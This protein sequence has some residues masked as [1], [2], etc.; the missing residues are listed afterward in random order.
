M[1]GPSSVTPL[2]VL[3]FLA[4]L[5]QAWEL[6]A[7]ALQVGSATASADESLVVEAGATNTLASR[8][9]ASSWV[10]WASDPKEQ[11]ALATK[12][13]YSMLLW[14][15]FVALAALFYNY[16]KQFPPKDV[17][18][19]HPKLLDHQWSFGLFA[20]FDTPAICCLTCC[21]MPIRWADTIR[22]AGLM[23]FW[24]ALVVFLGVMLTEIVSA[25]LQ[26]VLLVAVGTYYRQKLRAMFGLDY[27]DFSTVA[28][29]CLTWCCCGC[30]AIIQ[31][32]R[33]LEAAYQTKHSAIE[34]M[35]SIV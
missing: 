31:E 26:L 23:S 4:P 16:N 7:A 22:M 5:T 11:E 21:C 20:C 3:L 19:D 8:L 32:A 14:I 34:Q 15:P 10:A 33:Q 30:C 6:P 25:T 29:D 17:P 28:A 18:G 2:I 13:R 35:L 9:A 12:S 24:L 1:A 27:G